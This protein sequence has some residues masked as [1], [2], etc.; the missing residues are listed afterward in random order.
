VRRFLVDRRPTAAPDTETVV[1]QVFWRLGDGWTLR[2]R[3]EGPAGEPSRDSLTVEPGG[4]PVPIGPDEAAALFRAG[5]AHRLVAE[6]RTYGPVTVDSYVWEN[7]G[8]A[9]A[10]LDGPPP[11][12]CGREVTD[13]PRY[14]EES[15]AYEPVTTWAGPSR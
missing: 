9:V 1:R 2:L 7:A 3:R 13:D 10:S 4:R 11:P 14:A 15:L 12:W 6:R 5:R 8:L